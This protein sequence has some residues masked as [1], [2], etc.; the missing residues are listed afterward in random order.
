MSRVDILRI[1][2]AHSVKKLILQK[3]TELNHTSNFSKKRQSEICFLTN[4]RIKRKGIRESSM[5]LKI[6]LNLQVLMQLQQR[7]KA[8]NYFLCYVQP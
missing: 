4:G 2:M 3:Y 5:N 7:T 6:T 1:T 8:K